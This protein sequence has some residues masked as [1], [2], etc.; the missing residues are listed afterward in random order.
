MTGEYLCK[1]CKKKLEPHPEVCPYCHR[2]SKD[3]LTC[4]D[5]RTDKNNY[6]EGIIIP[7]AY[8]D[9]LKKLIIRLKYFHKTDIGQFLVERLNI[10]LQ[11][12]ESFQKIFYLPPLLRG[13]GS[14]IIGPEGFVQVPNSKLIISFIPSHRYRHYFVKG[15]NQSQLLAKKLSE[16]LHVPIVEIAK[17]QKHTKTQASLDRNGRLHNLKNAFSLVKNTQLTG[18]ETL[19]IVDDIT[20]TGSTINELAKLMKYHY[21]KIK[22]RGAVLGRH[23]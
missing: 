18:N 9:H 13:G 5:C 4:I 6:L 7:F 2:F 15:Y 22:V 20:T 19:L 3:Y 16:I 21:P 23:R 12:N 8:T 1:T 11:A 10:A 14:V 17:K